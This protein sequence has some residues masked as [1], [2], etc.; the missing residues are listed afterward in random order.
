MKFSSKFFS[1]HAL[2]LYHNR[3]GVGAIK[4]R[5]IAQFVIQSMYIFA[6]LGVEIVSPDYWCSLVVRLLVSVL[7]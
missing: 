6:G 5:A 1:Q 7:G 2:L 4:I 3:R